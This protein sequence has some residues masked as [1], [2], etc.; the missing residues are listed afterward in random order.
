MKKSE[1]KSTVHRLFLANVWMLLLLLLTLT[2]A[3]WGFG[4]WPSI[5][6]FIF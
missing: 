5:F 1:K 4:L 2:L 6:A 3:L